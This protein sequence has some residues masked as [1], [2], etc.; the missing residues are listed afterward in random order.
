LEFDLARLL[1]DDC[2]VFRHF[3]SSGGSSSLAE[4]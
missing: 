1:N 2:V 4:N 3:A